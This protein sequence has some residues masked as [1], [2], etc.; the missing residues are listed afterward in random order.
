VK[1]LANEGKE[2]IRKR[3]KLVM[4]A[5]RNKDGWLVVQEYESD[6]L[7]SNSEDKKKIKEAKSATEQKRKDARPHGSLGNPF[8]RSKTSGDNQPFSR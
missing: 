5:D 4:L 8:K 2:K 3:Q 1:R 7:A 6:D